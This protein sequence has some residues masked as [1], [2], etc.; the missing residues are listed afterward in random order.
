MENFDSS[1]FLFPLPLSRSYLCCPRCCL[2]VFVTFVALFNFVVVAAPLEGGS[3]GDGGQVRA[4]LGLE[5]R[6]GLDRKRGGG[7]RMLMLLLA[8]RPASSVVHP[9]RE[10]WMVR[11]RH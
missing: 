5:R 9:A 2:S 1:I 10:R 3:G 6:V 11:R 7:G 4:G 8:L